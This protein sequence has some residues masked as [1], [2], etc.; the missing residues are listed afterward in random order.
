MPVPPTPIARLPV[1]ALLPVNVIPADADALLVI[2]TL[3]T[4]FRRPRFTSPVASLFT[5][6]RS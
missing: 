6:V 5:T 1:A 3:R 2:A 4:S